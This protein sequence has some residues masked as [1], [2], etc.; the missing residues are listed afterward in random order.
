MFSL[1][2]VCS[3]KKGETLHQ[4]KSLFKSAIKAYGQFVMFLYEGNVY[5]EKIISFNEENVYIFAMVKSL[6]S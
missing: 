5:S 4:N 1:G 2:Y 6:K 3:K